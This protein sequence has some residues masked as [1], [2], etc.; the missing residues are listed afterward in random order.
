MINSEMY[1][2]QVCNLLYQ[3]V[4]QNKERRRPRS[5]L[6]STGT[7]LAQRFVSSTPP[8]KIEYYTRAHQ[9]FDSLTQSDEDAPQRPQLVPKEFLA[10]A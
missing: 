8:A 3:N 7:L 1:L 6:L 10:G 4:Y 5:Y 2:P 9:K